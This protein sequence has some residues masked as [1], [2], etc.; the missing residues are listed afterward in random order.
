ML[1]CA[2]PASAG[3]MIVSS[4]QTYDD[5][6]AMAQNLDLAIER[7][8]GKVIVKGKVFSLNEIVGPRTADNGFAVA[9][10]GNGVSVMGGR[11]PR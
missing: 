5:S 3:V 9:H 4:T 7:L 10:H 6:E 8:N 1:L 11:S 2:I